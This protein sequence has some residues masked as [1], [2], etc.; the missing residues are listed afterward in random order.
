MKIEKIEP[1]LI[2]K[3]HQK[4]GIV[5]QT[6]NDRK[7]IKEAKKLRHDV[8][9]EVGYITTPYPDG[10]IPDPE[11]SIYIVAL[12]NGEELMGTVRVTPGPP[13][14]TLAVWENKFFAESES[15]IKMLFDAKSA[16]IGSLAVKK[17][18]RGKRISW[19]L[20]KA[21]YLFAL[22]EKIDFYVA[23][24]DLNAYKLLQWL[25][26]SLIEIGPVMEYMGS[27]S[28]P[29]IIPIK[30]QLSSVYQKNPTYYQYVVG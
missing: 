16:E 13:F 30:D 19:G 23:G 12:L 22:I 24:M 5:F 14:E 4:D 29:I 20:Y 15:L 3:L 21:L 7:Q 18:A 6:I 27:P 8:Y 25:G 26:W 11:P 1:S 10:I 28:I 17:T 2:M 9:L